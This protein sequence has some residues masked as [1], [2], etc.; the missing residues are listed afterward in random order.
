MTQFH[1]RTESNAPDAPSQD[2]PV[3]DSPVQDWGK[4]RD[5]ESTSSQIDQAA[6]PHASP[7]ASAHQDADPVPRPPESNAA[8]PPDNLPP[9]NLPP[10]NLPTAERDLAD[11]GEQASHLRR[12][13]DR[14][15]AGGPGWKSWWAYGSIAVA[16][17]ILGLG[18]AATRFWTE[19]RETLATWWGNPIAPGSHADPNDPADSST[20]GFAKLDDPASANVLSIETVVLQPQAI[21]AWVFADGTARSVR[22]EYLTFERSGKIEFIKTG[23]AGGELRQGD[24]VQAGDVLARMDQRRYQ[25][26]I[27]TAES[28]LDEA[29]TQLEVAQ[30]DVAQADTQYQLART[31]LERTRSLVNS[32]AISRSEFD[33]AEATFKNAAA[34]RASVQAKLR[35]LDAGIASAEAK[36]SQAKLTLEETDLISPIDGII[37]YLNI[38]EGFYFTQNT[39]R[40]NS[41]SEALQTIPIIVIDPSSYEITVDIPAFEAGRIRVGQDVLISPGNLPATDPFD[42][43]TVSG[44]PATNATGT[45][46]SVNPAV[47][48]GGRS[49][50]VVVRT[51]GGAE[52]LQDGMFSACW[53]QVENSSEALVAPFEAFLFEDNQPYVFVIEAAS[54]PESGSEFSIARRRPVTIGIQGLESR[55]IVSG[56]ADGERVAT[57]GRYRLVDG[58]PVS[59]ISASAE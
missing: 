53:I 29:K 38:E 33:E 58:A 35:A 32:N 26:E 55:Q 15:D 13:P 14:R 10:E 6:P 23:P 5:R 42:Q 44:P 48:P 19:P 59:V 24:P 51:T 21:Q 46:F 16:V 39:V 54:E 57:T 50:Q 1:P 20:P 3:Q 40:T 56:V 27:K 8:L 47:N 2:S 45:V 34:V 9:E 41:E 28:V 17:L 36:L 52:N 30:A 37:A 31:Q 4:A 11:L 43:A 25:S 49:V 18:W 22:R 12:D 7:Q